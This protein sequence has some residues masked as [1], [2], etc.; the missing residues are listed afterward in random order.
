MVGLGNF[1]VLRFCRMLRVRIGLLYNIF[2]IYGSYM[3]ISMF[4]GLFFFG[5]GR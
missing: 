1:E 2:V 3:V 5:G 4:V